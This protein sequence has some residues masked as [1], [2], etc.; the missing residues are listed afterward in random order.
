[1]RMSINIVKKKKKCV[2]VSCFDYYTIRMKGIL[3]YFSSKKFETSYLIPDYN[4]FSGKA[5][6]IQDDRTALIHVPAYKKNMSF[7]RLYSHYVFAKGVYKFLYENQP[8]I[9]YCVIPPNILVREI[10]KFKRKFEN[11]RVIFDVFDTWP[12]SMPK[13]NNKKIFALP[14]KIWKNLREN[15]ISE[16]DLVVCVSKSCE[17]FLRTTHPNL[18]TR[19]VYPSPDAAT[20]NELPPHEFNIKDKITFCHL[21]NVNYIVDTELAVKLLS[22]LAKHKKISIHF[23]GAGNSLEN[24]INALADNGIETISHGVIF[25]TAMKSKIY[26]VC[27]LG[28]C[29]PRR[30]INS[31]MPLKA[32]DY[33]RSGL[34]FINNS[35]GDMRSIVEND[36][37]GI[38][39][40]PENLDETVKKILEL[41]PEKLFKMSANCLEKYNQAFVHDY[42]K[43]FNTIQNSTH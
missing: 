13:L 14:F 37:L 29:T 38:N 15:Y 42:D 20:L 5:S 25:D 7:T 16:A 28:L 34:P 2:C 3:N 35:L 10:I 36:E 19:V 24:F 9:I 11:T 6:I 39:I 32:V 23:I 43:I 27:D 26:S 40:N 8:D 17:K 31:T 30:E 41:T 1:M 22:L 18:N 21:G 4:H 33:I 12:E